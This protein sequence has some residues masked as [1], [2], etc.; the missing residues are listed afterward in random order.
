MRGGGGIGPR[1]WIYGR[2]PLER[3]LRRAMLAQVLVDGPFSSSDSGVGEDGEVKESKLV[4]KLIL[5]A[6]RE[7]I[8]EA[9]DWVNEEVKRNADGASKDGKEGGKEV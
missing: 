8:K 1:F 5:E 6:K 4:S 3:I 2:I 9:P 7:M